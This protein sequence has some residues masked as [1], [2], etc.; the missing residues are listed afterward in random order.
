[1]T[2]NELLWRTYDYTLKQMPTYKWFIIVEKLESLAII[3]YEVFK[4]GMRYYPLF[5]I[6]DKQSLV[7]S[8]LATIFIWADLIYNVLITGL[9][10]G[11]KLNLNF[12]FLK[13]IQLFFMNS[14]NHS[15][16]NGFFEFEPKQHQN[17]FNSRLLFSTSRIV[18]STVKS[19]PHFFCLSFVAIRI[20]ASLV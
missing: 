13:T 5:S 18:Y 11:L 16:K 10:E 7:C 15:I 3:I 20:T 12:N 8:L 6:L 19:L 2:P 4:I 1:M 14:Q 9:C 17:D